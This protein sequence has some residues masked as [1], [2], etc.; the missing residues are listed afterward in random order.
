MKSSTFRR[1]QAKK[2]ESQKSPTHA[3]FGGR[4]HFHVAQLASGIVEA[5]HQSQGRRRHLVF[6]KF[7]ALHHAARQ[8]SRVS[9]H[10]EKGEVA[11]SRSPSS[12]AA[13]I[14]AGRSLSKSSIFN[15]FSE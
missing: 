3:P 6:T 10:I 5:A 14:T 7:I 1:I 11:V 9:S 8:N 12:P 15:N 2:G 4:R 13:A